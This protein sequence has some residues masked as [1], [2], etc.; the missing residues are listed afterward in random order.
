VA[1][2]LNLREGQVNKFFREFWKLK[3]LNGL[4]EIY[5]QIEPYLPSFLKLHKALKK[6]G[7]NPN[8]VEWFANAIEMGAVKL[9]KLQGQHQSLQNRVWKME[10]RKQ[11]LERDCQSI[12]R[13]TVEL[14]Q[15]HNTVQQNF[16]ILTEKVNDLYNEKCQLEQFVSRFKNGNRKY[17]EIRG[18][19]QEIVN[20]LLAEQGLLLTSAIIA[21]VQA[22][23]ENPDKYNII[24]D[25]SEYDN[26]SEYH[27]GLLEVANSFM[28]FLS[29]QMVDK[30][31]VAAA[32]EKGE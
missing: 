32:T 22:L 23:R 19:A 12:Q 27:E 14:T 25:N 28:K 24:F 11:E 31:M 21:V 7:L 30:T 20:R 2:E 17:L 9:P 13:E 10:H 3:N 26:S 4:Y 29:R 5:P 6:R 8:N 18:I 1:I 16:D 15:T